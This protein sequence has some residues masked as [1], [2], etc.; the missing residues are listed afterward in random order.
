[1]RLALACLSLALA[2]AAQGQELGLTVTQNGAPVAVSV[3]DGI[4]IATLNAAPF[5]LV[6]SD[7]LPDTL[8][9]TF[10][11]DILFDLIDLPPEQGLFGPA[12]GYAR[13]PGP[14]APLFMTDPACDPG[15][16]GLPFNYLESDHRRGNAYPVSAIHAD[17]ASRGCLAD[18]RLPMETDLIGTI[19]P[20]YAVLRAGGVT[21][22][23]VL[24]FVGS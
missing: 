2:S 23:L 24:R 1:M 11:P 3:E 21:E 18:G 4:T 6:L 10:G 9:L 8:Y 16:Y 14:D 17:S 15:D 7:P 19:S 22:R 20:L 12:M 5:E 13:E